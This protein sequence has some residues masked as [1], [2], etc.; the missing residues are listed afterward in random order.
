VEAL[1]ERR[2]MLSLVVRRMIKVEGSII[3]A[4]GHELTSNE[5]RTLRIHPSWLEPSGAL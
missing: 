2:K 4:D 3:I 5:Q 1:E